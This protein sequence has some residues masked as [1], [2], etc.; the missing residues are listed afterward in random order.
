MRKRTGQSIL[1]NMSCVHIHNLHSCIVCSINILRYINT[2]LPSLYVDAW[3][4]R[5]YR[6]T[7][8]NNNISKQISR[9]PPKEPDKNST[10]HERQVKF[11]R[12]LLGLPAVWM[13]AA[14]AAA[15]DDVPAARGPGCATRCARGHRRPVPV[16]LRPAV[17][18][19]RRLSAQ[20][21]HR[22]PH[23]Q[24]LPQ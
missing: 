18:D 23:N 21:H 1:W 16:R 24:A 22:R 8:A 3:I 20:L 15:A 10:Y 5:E 13:L 7:T 4:D 11:S 12:L 19:P 9:K 2:T 17:R 6:Q 14:A